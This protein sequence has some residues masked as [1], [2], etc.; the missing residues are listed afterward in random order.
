LRCGRP[1]EWAYTVSTAVVEINARE[2]DVR[3]QFK[4]GKIPG[5]VYK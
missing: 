3:E 1:V 2:S 5:A 4:A